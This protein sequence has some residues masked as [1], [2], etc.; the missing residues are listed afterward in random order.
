MKLNFKQFFNESPLAYYGV[1]L[2]PEYE[3]E[4]NLDGHPK[5]QQDIAGKFSKSDAKIISNPKTT[6]I[7][8]EKL[9]NIGYNINIILY[10]KISVTDKT[11]FKR[12][13]KQYLQ[14]KNIPT[15]NHITFVKNGSSGDFLTPWMIFHTFGHAV[16]NYSLIDDRHCFPEDFN[17]TQAKTLF[18][19]KSARNTTPGW[20]ANPKGIT[21]REE[22]K[23]ELVAEFLW[24]DGHI[25]S[26]NL[27]LK[28]CLEKT[29][30]KSLDDCVG[31]IIYDYF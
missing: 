7:L 31:Q 22:L 24:N 26:T 4:R 29:I 14:N 28:E 19:F 25:R 13:V 5:Y 9:K 15:E 23:N 2:N 18:M 12:D 11:S 3:E 27:Q 10:E 20:G 6:Q 17:F 21:S 1:H 16:Q 8:K 30:K